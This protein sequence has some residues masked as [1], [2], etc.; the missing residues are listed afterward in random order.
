M[1]RAGFTE[2]ELRVAA[3]NILQAYLTRE[4]TREGTQARMVA[5]AGFAALC[6]VGATTGLAHTPDELELVVRDVVEQLP[7]PGTTAPIDGGPDWVWLMQ[8]RFILA[9][10]LDRSWPAVAA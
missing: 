6:E 10:R 7:P 5:E 8:A 9:R 4:A 2:E 1:I 3:S